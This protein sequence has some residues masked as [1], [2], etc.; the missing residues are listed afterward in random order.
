MFATAYI[1]FR[2]SLNL[3]NYET[4]IAAIDHNGYVKDDTFYLANYTAGVRMI[5]ITN[6]ANKTINEIG[7]FDT[8]PANN[9]ASFNGVWNVYPYFESGNIVISDIEGG[10]FIVRKSGT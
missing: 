1:T 6:I 5:D 8:R 9:L 7:F 10:L 2:F 4:N 3:T